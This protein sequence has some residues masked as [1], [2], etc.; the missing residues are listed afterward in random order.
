M[1]GAR[2]H[3]KAIFLQLVTKLTQVS[4]QSIHSSQFLK[5]FYCISKGIFVSFVKRLHEIDTC[6]L[7]IH[8]RSHTSPSHRDIFRHI[9]FQITESGTSCCSST[10]NNQVDILLKKIFTLLQSL[11]KKE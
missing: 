6:S 4:L 2:R 1:H 7:C 8:T 3:T 9:F 10:R 11:F 5:Y